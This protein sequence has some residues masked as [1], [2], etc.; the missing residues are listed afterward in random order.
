MTLR[1]LIL[2]TTPV[3]ILRIFHLLSRRI[4]IG[5]KEFTRVFD[6]RC[7]TH[8]SLYQARVAFNALKPG[9]DGRIVLLMGDWAREIV[10]LEYELILPQAR[11]DV[12]YRQL[13]HL[14]HEAHWYD[15]PLS[16][17]LAGML[18]E[19]MYNDFRDKDYLRAQRSRSI[20]KRSALSR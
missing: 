2:D 17:D 11:G 10:G 9:L 13:P 16:Y 4:D 8:T 20:A 14:I 5:R 7:L 19:D 18:L 15:S 12:I 6:H 3:S 1:P